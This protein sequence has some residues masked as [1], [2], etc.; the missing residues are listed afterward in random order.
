M[1]DLLAI[2]PLPLL[3]A[4]LGGV[5]GSFLNVVAYRLP[6]ARSVVHPGSAC[7]GCDTR[8]GAL[9]LVPVLSY[10]ALR[11][12]CRH[13]R[14]RISPRY[15]LV[16]LATALLA[17]AVAWVYGPQLATVALLVLLFGLIALTLIDLD[18]FWLPD[19]IVLPGLALGLMVNSFSLITTPLDAL[20]GAGLGYGLFWG[21]ATGY[22]KLRGRDGLGQGDWK[23]FAA[24]GAWMGASA[25]PGILMAA[26]G[27]GS[28]I[29]VLLLL[30]QRGKG[31]TALPFGPF[32][33]LGGL[34][35]I[36]LRGLGLVGQIG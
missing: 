30:T 24:L 3:A 31:N 2:Y 16:E 14:M 32:L 18:H 34:I 9:E 27:L 17:A 1:T 10:C 8:L 11:G 25:L 20:L 21:I 13:C 7:P 12:R 6:L 29:G 4:L 23:L 36:F 35:I 28:L 5:V 22:R 26:A 19:R 15:A 33:A